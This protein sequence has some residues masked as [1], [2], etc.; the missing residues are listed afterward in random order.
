MWGPQVP[1]LM[2]GVHLNMGGSPYSL[3]YGEPFV[4]TGTLCDMYC[5]IKC[6][7]D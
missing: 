6:V 1:T 3:E 2:H 4:K 7:S 5:K